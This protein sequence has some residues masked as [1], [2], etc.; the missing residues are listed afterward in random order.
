MK[1]KRKIKYTVELD[2]RDADRVVDALGK[3]LTGLGALDSADYPVYSKLVSNGVID[4]L[5]ALKTMIVNQI[6]DE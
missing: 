5:L 3:A 4:R 2:Q 6:P 1:V